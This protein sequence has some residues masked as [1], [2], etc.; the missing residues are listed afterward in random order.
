MQI[1][2]FNNGFELEII[3]PKSS[4]NEKPREV[5]PSLCGNPFFAL[6]SE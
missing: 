4:I 3:L 2:N 6:N 5:G 1:R